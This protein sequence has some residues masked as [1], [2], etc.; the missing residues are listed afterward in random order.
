VWGQ[1]E[2]ESMSLVE[3]FWELPE[4]AKLFMHGTQWHKE[5]VA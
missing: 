2:R 5:S 1:R 4:K 3:F